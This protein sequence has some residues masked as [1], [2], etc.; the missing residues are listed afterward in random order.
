[1]SLLYRLQPPS[2]EPGSVWLVGA[3]PGDPGLLTL[4]AAHALATADVV[5]HDA[6]VPS[7]IVALA[8]TPWREA[9]GKRAGGA[10][11]RQMRINERMIALARDGKR[12]LRLK[13]GDPLIF[14]RGGEEALAL[15]AAGVSFRIIPGVS[16]GIGGTGAAG[17]P[18]THR[19]LARSVLFAAGHDSHG[20]VPESLDFGALSRAAD[21]L[22]FYMALR[23]AGEIA[24]RLIAAGRSSIDQVAFI[25]EASTA[26]Q[27]VT[28][29]TLATAGAVAARLPQSSPTLIVIGPVVALRE[30]LG[31]GDAAPMRPA[32]D[33]NSAIA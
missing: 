1:M 27:R 33:L 17:I 22:V 23:R 30:V 11:V 20:D 24:E 3:G 10:R 5:L 4:H 14:G 26:R 15:A 31:A 25:A 13:G 32:S 29:A 12:V 18:L 6:L 21:V 2:F 9:V 28:T 19:S 7:E 16:A 8:E